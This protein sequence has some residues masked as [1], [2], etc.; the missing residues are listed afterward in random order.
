MLSTLSI[1][2]KINNNNYNGYGKKK[3]N[4]ELSSEDILHPETVL[5][6]F[7][8]KRLEKIKTEEPLGD[9]ELKT[10]QATTKS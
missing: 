4:K 7:E 1:I 9:N 8:S 3:V 6:Y 5:D 2:R 10:G